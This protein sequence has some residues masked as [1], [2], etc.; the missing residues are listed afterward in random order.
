MG[1]CCVVCAIDRM[2]LEFFMNFLN[3]ENNK[4]LRIFVSIFQVFFAFYANSNIKK[5]WCSKKI[6]K[7]G[8]GGGV[9]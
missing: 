9:L 2:L 5:K 8:G 3:I 6:K 7:Y 1:V 4:I